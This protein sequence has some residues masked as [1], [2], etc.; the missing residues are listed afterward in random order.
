MPTRHARPCTGA[1]S[2]TC[3]FSLA[4]AGQAGAGERHPILASDRQD[5]TVEVVSNDLDY[6][7]DITRDGGTLYITE[8]AGS[9]LRVVEGDLTRM[10][11]STSRPIYREGG[12]GLLGMA[13][14]PTFAQDATGY[15]YHSEEE[16]DGSSNRVI[17]ARFD[18]EAWQETRVLIDRIPGHRLYNGGRL[19]FGPD[20]MLYITTGWTEDRQRPQDPES[21]AGKI[22]RIAPDGAIPADNPRAGS[23]VWSLGH[24]NPQG[25]AW[26]P[27]GALYAVEHGQS[28]HDEINLIM[29]GGN[30]GWPIIQGDEQRAG[31]TAPWVHSGRRTWAPSGAAFSGP[32][33]LIAALGAEGLFVVDEAAGTLKPVVSTGERYRDVE[34]VGA[35]LWVIT[36]NRSPRGEG[37]SADRLLRLTLD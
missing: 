23:P 4:M 12:R 8:A 34:A 10:P 20:G 1:I 32:E 15:F 16:A 22:L 37:P 29:P 17:A 24:R 26:S 14:S 7:W 27:D 18:G 25:L 19:G 13:L 35:D 36:T 31:M 28:A 33:L 21:L 30:Y 9:V 5:W 6:P 11:L 3:L 2:L